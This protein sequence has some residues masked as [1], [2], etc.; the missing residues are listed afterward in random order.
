MLSIR[1]N[2]SSFMAKNSLQTGTNKL[3]LAIERMTTGAKINHAKDNAAN[4]SINTNMTTKIGAYDVAA[5]NVAMGL[6]MVTTAS[7]TISQM[8]SHATRLRELATQARNG[9][10]G[11]QSLE[12]IASE[13]VARITEIDR[14]YNTAQYNGVSLFNNKGYK[15][16]DHLPQAGDSGFIDEGVNVGVNAGAKHNGFIENPVTYTDSRLAEMLASGDLVVLET[17]L[18]SFDST[19]SYLIKDK[20]QLEHFAKLVNEGKSSSGVTFILGAD[21]DLG[22][23][24]WTAIGTYTN[25][26][27]GTFDGNGH[28]ISNLKIDKPTGWYQGLFGYTSGSAIKNVGLE[29]GSVNGKSRT[30]SLV[31]A[32]NSSTIANCYSTVNVVGEDERTGGLVGD[33]YDNSTII[34]CYAVGNVL[35]HSNSTGGLVGF[36]YV[37]SIINSY[38]T[39]DVSGQ[40]E[41]VGG[42]VGYNYNNSTITNSYA[43]GD[44]SGQGNRTGGLVGQNSTNSTIT[45]S[46]A[47]GNVTGQG[48]YTGGLIGLNYII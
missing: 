6:D 15:I 5:D 23:E 16:A 36:N 45:N 38:A 10:Y 41:Y 3:N 39:G 24:E 33:N 35:G 8:Q 47:T 42:L 11:A 29:G 44:V 40:D 12:A 13:A 22:G 27:K 28:K 46:Y 17:D 43:T 9:T 25:S 14:L 19:K 48:N 34:N 21:I 30:G 2:L 7:D 18:E 31:G 20:A 32:N 4:Y 26:F 37:S 1:T